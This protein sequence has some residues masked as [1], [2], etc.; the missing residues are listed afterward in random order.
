M[1]LMVIIY[2]LPV[3]YAD[4]L[5]IISLLA[6]RAI[7]SGP[8]GSHGGWHLVATKEMFVRR[9]ELSILPQI[10]AAAAHDYINHRHSQ[11]S[12]DRIPDFGLHII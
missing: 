7:I 6:T 12:S 5:K 8:L 1:P 2:S 9:T 4:L 3:T 10:K 11:S